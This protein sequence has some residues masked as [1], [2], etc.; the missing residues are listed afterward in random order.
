MSR[1]TTTFTI[2]LPPEMADKVQELMKKEKRTRSELFRE[3]LRRYFNEQEWREIVRYGHT[4]AE[5]KGIRE[6][7]VEDIVDAGR[8]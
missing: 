2:S 5:Q 8:E 6:D 4:K 7:Q 1:T 3:A